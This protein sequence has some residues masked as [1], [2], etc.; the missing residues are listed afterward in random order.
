VIRDEAR[1]IFANSMVPRDFDSVEIP[2]PERGRPALIRW[3]DRVTEQSGA[4]VQNPANS[5]V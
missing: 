2:L 3:E 4:A 5:G 1:E